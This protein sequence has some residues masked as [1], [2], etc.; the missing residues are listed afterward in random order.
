M[1]PVDPNDH[2]ELVG[3]HMV[4]NF[5]PSFSQVF[6]LDRAFGSRYPRPLT[7][8]PNHY[9]HRS[10]QQREYPKKPPR[11]DSF[12]P[13]RYCYCYCYYLV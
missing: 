12:G 5:R 8:D 11:R 2:A 1:F 4:I 10:S 9:L 13:V 3:V 6:M 7:L